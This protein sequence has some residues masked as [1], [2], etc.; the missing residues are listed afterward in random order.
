MI[1]PVTLIFSPANCGRHPL[2]SCGV[3]SRYYHRIW[4]IRPQLLTSTTRRPKGTTLKWL[5]CCRKLRPAN[6]NWLAPFPFPFDS[7]S[8]PNNGKLNPNGQGRVSGPKLLLIK[9]AGRLRTNLVQQKQEKNEPLCWLHC[10]PVH[11]LRSWPLRSSSRCHLLF[12]M[13]VVLLCFA[14]QLLRAR[15]LASHAHLLPS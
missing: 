1:W 10:Q 3:P 4:A 8:E 5:T 14:Q 13:M 7:C 2:D 9:F 11:S 12:A 6:L 15:D